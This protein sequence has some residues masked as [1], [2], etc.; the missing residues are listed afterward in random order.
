MKY[1]YFFFLIFFFILI[2][3]VNGLKVSSN[4]INK[5]IVFDDNFD[6]QYEASYKLIPESQTYIKISSPSPYVEFNKDL[7]KCN[8]ECNVKVIFHQPNMKNNIEFLPINFE[9]VDE[10]AKGSRVS[11]KTELGIYFAKLRDEVFCTAQYTPYYK[12]E[13]FIIESENYNL[14]NKD[15]TNYYIQANVYDLNNSL[16]Y[17]EKSGYVSL[18]SGKSKKKGIAIPVSKLSVGGYNLEYYTVC[19]D[20]IFKRQSQKID[21]GKPKVKILGIKTK[22][23]NGIDEFNINL[24]NLWHNFLESRINIKIFNDDNQIKDNFVIKLAPKQKRTFNKFLD[25]RKLE[26]GEYTMNI[27]LNYQKK[28]DKYSYPITIYNDE[29][30]KTEESKDI[31]FPLI[32]IILII[33]TG[34]LFV[35]LINM[36]RR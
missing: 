4:D 22:Y 29:I 5:L 19:D 32:T 27:T 26:K 20:K 36:K 8:N 31:L 30:I 33:V 25:L 11:V 14:W 10:N 18:G 9:K 6:K 21:L 7:I 2:T 12:D 16:L 28:I 17:Q 35:I 1:K 24:M 23:K 13:Y 3:N 34:F 15:V